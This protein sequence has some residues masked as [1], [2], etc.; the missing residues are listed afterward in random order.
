MKKHSLL[1][2]V[3][4]MGSLLPAYGAEVQSR[5]A[6]ITGGGGDG[7]KCTIEVDVD[8]VAEVEVYGDQGFI[9]TL[10]GGLSTWRRFQCSSPM[11]RNMGDFRFRG[12]DGRGRVDLVRDPRSNGGRAVVRIEDRD[13][14]REGYTFDLE[15]RGSGG[16]GGPGGPGGPGGGYP[17]SGGN[18]PPP[19]RRPDDRRNGRF[20]FTEA[21]N[22]CKD[23][24][25]DRAR[26]DYRVRDV[27]FLDVKADNNPGRNDWIVGQFDGR[28]G[29]DLNRFSFS[30]SVDFS[31][32][33][34]RSVDIRRR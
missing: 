19:N 11:P 4:I 33:R 1:A 14:G 15:W 24:A 20:A 18:Y 5:R 21:V 29:P 7:G 6:N 22:I 27:E 23:A 8:D 28:R 9:R 12:V 31:S 16:F 30:C 26:R 17:P 34:V 25:R 10:A 13:G 32:G 3:T 2:A